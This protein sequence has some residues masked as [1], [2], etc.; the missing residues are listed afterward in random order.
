MLCCG[1]VVV[2]RDVVVRLDEDVVDE[3]D[4]LLVVSVSVDGE[5]DVAVSVLV[6][7]DV[8]V[9]VEDVAVAVDVV[10]LVL[11]VA[12]AVDVVEDVDV[13]DVSALLVVSG[14]VVVLRDVVVRLDED[15]VVLV[16]FSVAFIG[17]PA[18]AFAMLAFERFVSWKSLGLMCMPVGTANE[19]ARSSINR[20]MEK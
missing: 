16:A 11:D 2:L 7:E 5:V 14:V 20:A 17:L 9:S 18:E 19:R 12:V 8:L 1:V 3:A 4:V 6:V 10:E 15:V 13:V